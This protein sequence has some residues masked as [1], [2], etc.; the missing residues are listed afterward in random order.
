MVKTT[1]FMNDVMRLLKYIFRWWGKNK[2]R[3]I[4]DNR[5]IK[6]LSKHMRR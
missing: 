6:W 1:N 2:E 4:G 5:F 3:T